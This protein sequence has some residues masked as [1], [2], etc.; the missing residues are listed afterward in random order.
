LSPLL[1]NELQLRDLILPNRIVVS[2]MGQHSAPG[3]VVSDWHVMHLGQFAISG[4]GLVFTEAVYV[5]PEGRVSP[6]DIGLWNDEQQR[7]LARVVD[8]CREHGGAKLGVQLSHA[9]RK[10]SVA[11]SWAGHAALPPGAGGWTPVAPSPVGYTGRNAPEA[12]DLST[13]REIIQAFQATARRA[14]DLQFDL[15]ELHAAHGYLLH[16]FLSPLANQRADEYGGSLP[17]RMRYPLQ[18][19]QAIRD[20]WPSSKPIGVRVSATDW[21]DGGWSLDETLQFCEE[22][23]IRGCDFICASSGGTTPLQKIEVKPL[24]QVPFAEAI[25]R[26]VNIPTIAV[27]LIR[28]P[29]EAEGILEAGQADLIAIARGMLVNPRWAWHAAEELGAE[30]YFPKQYDRAHPS[31]RY[32]DSFGVRKNR[33][34][35]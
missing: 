31:L 22:L 30:V 32:N 18:V 20:V 13:M 27:G 1:F 5:S 15:I 7:A 33:R 12:L 28:T 16:N 29:T 9:G 8:F 23:K 3:G 2:P 21:A 24:Y 11:P 6:D 14:N 35:V 4:A 25:R 34:P 17:N 19:F 10:A 26:K